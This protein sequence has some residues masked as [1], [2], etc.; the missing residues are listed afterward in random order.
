MSKNANSDVYQ[1]NSID[2][3]LPHIKK[4]EPI[5]LITLKEKDA[6][7]NVSSLT[8]PSI[9]FTN[10]ETVDESKKCLEEVAK[11]KEDFVS[12]LDDAHTKA[13]ILVNCEDTKSAVHN[14]GEKQKFNEQGYVYGKVSS[15]KSRCVS[16]KDAFLKYFMFFLVVF[17]Q[18]VLAGC[19]VGAIRSV[20]YVFMKFFVK[21]LLSIMYTE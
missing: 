15:K 21:Y 7:E 2:D 8:Q 9:Y 3:I 20:S 11:S 4:D 10:L 1:I 5:N 13:W 18:I 6:L 12:G 16:F 17:M 19:Y 14:D